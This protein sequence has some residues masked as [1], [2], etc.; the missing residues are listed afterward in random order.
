VSNLNAELSR[1]WFEEVWNQHRSATIDE[2]LSPECVGHLETGDVHGIDAFKRFHGE[3]LGAFPDICVRVEAVVAD[4]DE[5]VS[6]GGRP[7]ATPET[8]SA[9]TPRISRLPFAA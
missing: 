4:G 2:L 9:S 1:R 7:V 8:D 3:F 5:V 6:R